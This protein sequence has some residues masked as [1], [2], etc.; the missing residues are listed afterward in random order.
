MLQPI[1][2]DYKRKKVMKS[3][4]ISESNFQTIVSPVIIKESYVYGDNQKSRVVMAYF[5]AGLM[6]MAVFLS[7][8]YQFTAITGEKQLKITEQIVSA[9]KPQV[10][11]DGKIYGIS[12]TGISSMLTY[13]LM[14]I[15]GAILFFSLPDF[16]FPAY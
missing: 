15:I 5:F 12:L 9:V 7:F 4:N 1:L 16:P 2:Q 14:S 6:I 13:S 10:W 8:A 3:L 11:M